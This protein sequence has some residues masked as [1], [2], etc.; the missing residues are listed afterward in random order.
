MDLCNK[1]RRYFRIAGVTVG[2]ESDLDFDAV[3]FG[4]EFAP[5]AADGPGDDNVTLYHCFKK[6]DI[7]AADLGKELCRKQAWA[8][9]HKD[10]TWF[11]RS[12]G[13][14]EADNEVQRLAVFDGAHERGTIYSPP[15]DEADVREYGWDSLF[16]LATDQIWL[17][18]LLAD[19]HAVLLHSAGVI[20][21]GRGLLFVGH[22]GAG[23]S[24]IVE[25]LKSAVTGGLGLRPSSLEILCD[26]RN[27]VRRW[28]EGWRVHGTWSHG[29]VS[30]VSSASAPLAAIL[31]LQ[32]DSR[33]EIVPMTDRKGIWRILLATLIKA[34]VT[35]EWW[36][37][38]LSVLEQ[39]VSEVQCYS[40]H[41]DKSGV[42]VG[43]LLN[44]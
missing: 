26:D 17:T 7:S 27:V 24:T 13:T 41:F 14:K 5:F 36:Q 10:D 22:S 15:G 37:K 42:I 9:S 6:P 21:N 8:V 31:F 3:R 23:K 35:A 43:A 12:L 39:I 44:L 16:L 30:D 28:D 25:M 40:M 20:L 11:Y 34:M 38:E 2:V 1:H 33:N 18:Q 32:Q 29:D 19:R 4:P